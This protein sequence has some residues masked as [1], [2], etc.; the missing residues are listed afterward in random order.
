MEE[1]KNVTQ[2]VTAR[3]LKKT[4]LQA[5]LERLF[6]GQTEFNIRVSLT[7]L[8]RWPANRNVARR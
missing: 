3:Y 2:N 5:L 7:P 1:N 6:P 8:R 4:S